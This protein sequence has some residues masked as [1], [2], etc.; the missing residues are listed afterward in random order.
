MRNLAPAL[1]RVPHESVIVNQ[2]SY[3]IKVKNGT[4]KCVTGF[5]MDV[6]HEIAQLAINTIQ[7]FVGVK[8][9]YDINFQYT[10]KGN[11]NRYN[12]TYR[13][14]NLNYVK[15]NEIPKQFIVLYARNRNSWGTQ[16]TLAHEFG[17]NLHDCLKDLRPDIRTSC[18][19]LWTRYDLAENFAEAFAHYILDTLYHTPQQQF[20]IGDTVKARTGFYINKNNVQQKNYRRSDSFA[21]DWE[22]VKILNRRPASQYLQLMC[23]YEYLITCN[24]GKRVYQQ[25]I[26]DRLLERVV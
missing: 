26:P 9:H 17:H 1:K 25:W 4:K 24:R 3:K 7:Q 20:N 2:S 11:A 21:I 15:L 12:G 18:A 10:Y 19:G 8:Q 23:D 14:S 22:H 13:H 5:N 6:A 16:K